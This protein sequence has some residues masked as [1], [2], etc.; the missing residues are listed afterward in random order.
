MADRVHRV[1]CHIGVRKPGRGV[2]IGAEAMWDRR[3]ELS[4][5]N[6]TPTSAPS[7]ISRSR[8]RGSTG[9][10]SSC[11][12]ATR[13]PHRP[14]EPVVAAP[15]DR[16]AAD[17]VVISDDRAVVSQSTV[18]DVVAAIVRD[19]GCSDGTHAPPLASRRWPA[20]AGK[21]MR[22]CPMQREDTSPNFRP[23]AP[24]LPGSPQPPARFAMKVNHDAER[25][26][27]TET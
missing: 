17:G 18:D 4:H 13:R 21:P 6:T 5:R 2:G 11:R 1:A 24:S 19:K 14:D 15:A 7:S 25:Q 20:V 10:P 8:C 27:R 9:T 26:Q 3:A 22:A 23:R 16:N 12:C